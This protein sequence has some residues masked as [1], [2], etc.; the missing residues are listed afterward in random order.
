M[1][2]GQ[3][4]NEKGELGKGRPKGASLC[5]LLSRGCWVMLTTST[6]STKLF[7]QHRFGVKKS[8]A[9]LKVAYL[10]CFFYGTC[11]LRNLGGPW[12]GNS[13]FLNGQ[14]NGH[15][16]PYLAML[17]NIMVFSWFWTMVRSGIPKKKPLHCGPCSKEDKKRRGLKKRQ[18]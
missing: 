11:M 17:H 1:K 4:S 18:Y 5:L 3:S 6:F 13:K 12:S 15:N 14:L 10:K 2:V 9:L 7:L 8:K 16:D